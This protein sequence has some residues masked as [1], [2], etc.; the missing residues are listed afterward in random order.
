M[1]CCSNFHFI[2]TSVLLF[3]KS[4]VKWTILA[5]FKWQTKHSGHIVHVVR[6]WPPH[7]QSVF[8]AC[9]ALLPGPH[10][11]PQGPHASAG[12]GAARGASLGARS[13]PGRWR[14]CC[15]QCPDPRPSPRRPRPVL[16]GQRT[17]FKPVAPSGPAALACS[18]CACLRCLQGALC[19]RCPR[20]CPRLWPPCPLC[21]W[22]RLSPGPSPLSPYSPLS[23][24]AAPPPRQ[25]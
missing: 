15:G 7:L 2:L 18:P 9:P 11:P 24:P 19:A 23:L 5:I 8:L 17:C 16:A 1:P 20:A 12:G 6:P 4:G 10:L 21:L 3:F 25:R 22:P 14:R 13:R